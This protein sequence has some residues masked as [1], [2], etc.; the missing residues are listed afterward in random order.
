MKI[1][2]LSLPPKRGY[3]HLFS[4]EEF[5]YFLYTGGV[6]FVI[7]CLLYLTATVVA[8]IYILWLFYKCFQ[9]DVKDRKDDNDDNDV[10][11][12]NSP[13]FIGRRYRDRSKSQDED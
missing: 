9:V 3:S 2:P 7:V 11:N 4:V 8:P 6:S 10:Y 5:L 13:R 12:M 1:E